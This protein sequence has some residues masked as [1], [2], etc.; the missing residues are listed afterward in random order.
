MP[1]N[2]DETEEIGHLRALVKEQG[3][4]LARLRDEII[5]SEGLEQDLNLPGK[6][7]F[8]SKTCIGERCSIC[9][10]PA[11]HKVGE[12]IAAGDP[13]PARHN[14]TAYVCCDHF[15]MIM[16]RMVFCPYK[17]P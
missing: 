10:E 3:Q 8:V 4:E 6:L 15:R 12:E 16:G 1:D 9:G 2:R 13:L 17:T 5:E 11:T 14:F 7:H